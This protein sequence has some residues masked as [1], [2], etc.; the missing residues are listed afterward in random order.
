VGDNCTSSHREC[1]VT[2]DD[3]EFTRL[4]KAIERI[5]DAVEKINGRMC[6][7][8]SQRT[9]SILANSKKA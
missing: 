5:A 1:S 3:P 2:F 7:A 4:V 6:E 8:A 9:A